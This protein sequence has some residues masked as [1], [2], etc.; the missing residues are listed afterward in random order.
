[1]KVQKIEKKQTVPF[2]SLYS[3]DVFESNNQY[4][5]VT[6]TSPKAVRLEDGHIFSFVLDEEVI[7]LQAEITLT[8]K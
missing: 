3:G 2:R 5:I 7:P 8:E 1:M 4:Y 6:E